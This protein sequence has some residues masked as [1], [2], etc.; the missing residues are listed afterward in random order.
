MKNGNY[1]DSLGTR[2]WYKSD[3][4]HRVD[5]PAVVRKDGSEIWMINGKLCVRSYY[6]KWLDDHGMNIDN[7]S[8]DDEL[9]IT[10][11]FKG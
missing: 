6:L 4:M 1:E 3:L 7:L 9:F 2:F 8:D 5:G 10:L 11:F